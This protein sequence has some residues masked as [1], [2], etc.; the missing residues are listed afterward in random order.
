MK[1]HLS[2]VIGG[3]VG[4]VLATLHVGPSAWQFWAILITA[5]LAG[6]LMEA[7]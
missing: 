5:G 1:A 6:P 2:A 3:I 4:G 7:L